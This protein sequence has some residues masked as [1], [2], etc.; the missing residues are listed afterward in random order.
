MAIQEVKK[1]FQKYLLLKTT[2]ILEIVLAT[3]LANKLPGDPLWLLIIAPPSSAKTEIISSLSDIAGIFPLSSLTAHTL[4]SGMVH[5]EDKSLLP[6]LKGKIITLKDFTSI[7]TMHREQRAE[8]L[9][10]LR[11]IYDGRYTKCF[12]TGKSIDWEGKVGIIAGVTPVID[13]HYAIFQML[14]ERF[15][16]YRIQQPDPVEMAMKGMENSG[17]ENEIRHILKNSIKSLYKEIEIPQK[18][19]ALPSPIKE[20]IAHLAAFCVRARS[21]SVRDGRTSMN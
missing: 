18:Q 5:E 15:I 20:K 7:I 19:I 10:Q 8:V 6:K 3:I 13:T 12:G 9:S 2:D 21:G 4:V 1:L 16:Q 14:G 17:Q 11:E